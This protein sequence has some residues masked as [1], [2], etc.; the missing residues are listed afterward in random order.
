ME[1]ARRIAEDYLDYGP[2][3]DREM[4]ALR[5]DIRDAGYPGVARSV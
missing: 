1:I 2:E 5:D 4:K 3:Y